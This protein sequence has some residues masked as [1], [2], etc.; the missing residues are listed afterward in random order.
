MINTTYRDRFFN[1][2]KQ[3]WAIRFVRFLFVGGINTLFSY[4]VYAIFILLHVHY[5]IASF[6]ST[7]IGIIFNFFTT[8]RIVFDNK[9]FKLIFKFFMVYGV[10]YLVNLF[11]LRIFDQYGVNMLIAGAFTTLP[12]AI[13]SYLLNKR[14]VFQ[15]SFDTKE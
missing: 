9:D 15:N 8:G 7:V 1:F 10:T 13:L 2:V 14:F 3:I 6:L 5:G 11:F 12:I 4:L